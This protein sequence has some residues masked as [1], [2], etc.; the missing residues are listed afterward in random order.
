M[1]TCS[2]SRCR[3][4]SSAALCCSPCWFPLAIVPSKSCVWSSG[5]GSSGIES[6]NMLG[7]LVADEKLDGHGFKLLG[8]VCLLLSRFLARNFLPGASRW[9]GAEDWTS[10][11]LGGNVTNDTGRHDPGSP[12]PSEQ[13]PGPQTI[14]RQCAWSA[15]FLSWL[16]FMVD[17]SVLSQHYL[18]KNDACNI[19][20]YVHM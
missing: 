2:L 15:F 3:S 6:I 7:V 17:M 10:F 1:H 16:C 14:L 11:R 13:A 19:C 4:A 9:S 18:H 12:G 8:F 20:K 5:I